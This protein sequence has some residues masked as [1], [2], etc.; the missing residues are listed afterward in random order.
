VYKIN[1]AN[2]DV[3]AEFRRSPFGRHSPE[4]QYVLNRLRWTSLDQRYI[5]ICRRPKQEWLLGR[6]SGE[7]GKPVDI[8]TDRIFTTRA[9]AEWEVF[10]LRWREHTGEELNDSA[11]LDTAR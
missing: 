7:R 11:G 2:R 8:V 10:K 1:A 4:L 9:D 5:L 6:L 3:I